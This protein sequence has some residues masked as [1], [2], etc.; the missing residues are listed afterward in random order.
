MARYKNVVWNLRGK[1]SDSTVED[2]VIQL[3]LL[4]DIRDALQS[5]DAKLGCYRIPKALDAAVRIDKRL[6]KKVKLP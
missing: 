6:A 3:A 2:P 5:I 1:D 4:M